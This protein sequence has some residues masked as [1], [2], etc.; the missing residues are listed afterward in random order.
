VRLRAIAGLTA[1]PCRLA[2]GGRVARAALVNPLAPRPGV[3][4]PP[5]IAPVQRFAVPLVRACFDLAPR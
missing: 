4:N 5:A 3:R 1:D 2:R